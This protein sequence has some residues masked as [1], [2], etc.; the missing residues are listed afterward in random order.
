[1]GWIK[2]TISKPPDVRRFSNILRIKVA[3]SSPLLLNNGDQRNPTGFR[4]SPLAHHS[5]SSGHLVPTI[6]D[7]RQQT[8][9]PLAL[10]RLEINTQRKFLV[11][12]HAMFL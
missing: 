7:E 8:Y 10:V 4:F 2:Y 11:E 9:H 1:M 12:K 3:P 6:T 5:M